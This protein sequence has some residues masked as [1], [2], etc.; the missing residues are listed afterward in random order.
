MRDIAL[1]L[2]IFGTLPFI[3]MR[4]Y[5]GL[6]VWSW[7]DYMSPNRLTY[8]F[9]YGF[10]W[11]MI[12][13]CVTL[14]ALAFGRDSKRMPVSAVTLLLFAFLIW[15]GL[16]TI[17]A[18][19]HAAALQKYIEFAKTLVMVFAT[20]M[21]VNDRERMHWL[22]WVIVGSLGFYGI[23]GGL[24]T[25]IHGGVNHVLGPAGT[26]IADNNALA[27]ALSMTIPLMRYLQLHSSRKQ[28]R[29][30]LGVAMLLTG[31]AVLGTY[32]RGGLVALVI[33]SG[34]LFV[35]SRGR[36]TVVVAALLVGLV[37][38]HFMPA[39]WTARMDTLHDASQ[40][41]S[42]ESRMQSW[43]FATQIAIHKPVFG[44]GF[45]VY[46]NNSMWLAYG[47]DH[48]IRRAIHSIYF[49]V[50]GEQGFIG[51]GL[52]LALLAATW[53]NCSLVRRRTRG[54]PE[55]RWAF[56]L[57]SMLQ[58]A[59]VA[60]MVAGAFLPMT[61]FDFAWQLMAVSTVLLAYV[62]Q[63]QVEAATPTRR[64]RSRGAPMLASSKTPKVM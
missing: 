16:T 48:A 40:T 11:V 63:L 21:L 54:D 49:R 15:T 41:S 8:G 38:W 18:V 37:A 13:A 28:V 31:V 7:L 23:K 2:I 33:V 42:G 4:P 36:V 20:L 45:D 27:L 24:F 10:P 52:F 58:V 51:L 34:A 19:E 39:E 57:A 29:I 64:P 17:F 53:L 32:S 9:A 22:M 60:F 26:F 47:P 6:L 46:L 5:L 43:A 44:G 35:K 61:Y 59:L 3:L 30:G 25:I 55:Q 14:V 12:V 56:D 62:T 1:A 50:L